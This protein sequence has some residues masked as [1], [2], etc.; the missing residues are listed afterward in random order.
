MSRRQAPPKF[1]PKFDPDGDVEVQCQ[2]F[3]P[4]RWS[5]RETAKLVEACRKEIAALRQRA[6]LADRKERKVDELRA[7][8]REKGLIN[9]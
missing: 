7:D 3:H 8:L 9:G 1:G 5:K 4:E 2:E 6:I